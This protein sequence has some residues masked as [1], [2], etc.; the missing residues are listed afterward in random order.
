MAGYTGPQRGT[1][2]PPVEKQ[3]VWSLPELQDLLDE[4]LIADWQNRPHDGL[5]DPLMPGKP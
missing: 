4:W 3:A 5:R 1:P 2:R